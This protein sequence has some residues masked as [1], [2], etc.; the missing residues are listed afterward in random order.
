VELWVEFCLLGPLAVRSGDRLLSIPH[1][2]QRTL[3][4]AL[5][6]HAG[7][8]IPADELAELLW[9]GRPPLSARATLQNYVKRLR[10]AL[11]PLGQARLRTHRP[12]YVID[13]SADEVDLLRFGALCAA[14][15]VAA[16]QGDWNQA[17]ARLRAALA[18]W[19]GQPFTGVPSELL[20][21]TESP[22]LNEMRLDALE[23]SIDAEMH[24]GRH[25][26]VADELRQLVAAEPL[27]ERPRGLLMLA[28]Y[29]AGRAAEALAQYRDA[30]RTL[31]RDLGLEPGPRLRQLHRQILAGD[32]ALDLAAAPRPAVSRPDRAA[33][34]ETAAGR[35][36]A[37]EHGSVVVPRQLPAAVAHITGRQAESEALT[38]QLDQPAGASRAVT[39][40]TIVGTAGIG[41]TALALH[42]S[43]RVADRFRDG[44]LYANLR[45]FGPRV[46]PAPPEEVIRGF[47]GALGVPAAELPARLEAQAAL[48][49][50]LLADRSMLVL[51][52]NA[53]DA[54]Q[55]RPLLPGSAACVVLVTSRDQLTGL[56]VAEGA[57]P[58][59]LGLLTEA[60]A[61]DLLARRLGAARLSAEPEAVRELIGLCARLPLALAVVA[62]RASGR[63][64]VPL[65]QITSELRAARLDAL[66]TGE[67]ATDLR[68]VL[69]WSYGCLTPPAAAMFRALGLH[70][71]PDI[72]PARAAAL[73]GVDPRQARAALIELARAHLIEE[74]APGRFALY[75]LLRAYAT[76]LA[77]LP[78]ASGAL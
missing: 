28:L 52:D 11:G 36:S 1:G 21:L 8:V 58:V 20:A 2:K 57:Y 13:A 23:T 74:H 5:L 72:T 32:P 43:H 61:A 9:E 12:G 60:D 17:A 33:T 41:K 54:E 39:I 73:A 69:S 75:G 46:T 31:V 49:R 71:G 35:M 53:R 7:E 15:H 14:G 45:G 50:S 77:V 16:R 6:A 70:P 22:R 68:A 51:L 29:R 44:Q 48:Y 40:W 26:Q 38:Q 63:P 34:R 66:A 24:L 76:D 59:S 62:G 25:V 78:C 67:P 10:Q 42:W 55:V 64:G 19:R 47:L 56:V 4:A 30:R 27:R 37:A 65:T 18:L 3:L